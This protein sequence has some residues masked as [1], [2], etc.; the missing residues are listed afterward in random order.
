VSNAEGLS[1]LVRRDGAVVVPARIANPLLRLL[2]R[3]ILD[4]RK[5]NGGG[6]MSADL[7]IVLEA[8][9]ISAIRENERVSS[10]NGTAFSVSGNVGIAGDELTSSEA[11]HLLECTDRAVRKACKE[12]RLV[13]RKVGRQWLIRADALDNYRFGKTAS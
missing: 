4:I 9:Q 13:G 1:S 10:A 6:V 11:A 2:T 3:G 7:M 12:Q 8:L 5:A